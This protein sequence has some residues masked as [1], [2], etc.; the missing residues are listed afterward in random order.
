MIAKCPPIRTLQN[1]KDRTPL[2]Q[3][4]SINNSFMTQNNC[5]GNTNIDRQFNLLNEGG[6]LKE[7]RQ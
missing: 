1:K 3:Q 2:G 5:S 4:Q 6:R 7:I